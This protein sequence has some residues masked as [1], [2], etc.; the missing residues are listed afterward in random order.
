MSLRPVAGAEVTQP[1]IAIYVTNYFEPKLQFGS[2]N[3]VQSDRRNSIAMLTPNHKE[4]EAII[5]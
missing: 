4:I 5:G 3:A 1:R 2:E